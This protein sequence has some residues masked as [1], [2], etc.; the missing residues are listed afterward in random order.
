MMK[1]IF[2]GEILIFGYENIKSVIKSKDRQ[3]KTYLIKLNSNK[4]FDFKLQ[5]IFYL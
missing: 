1:I 4:L 5:T 3:C 2:L